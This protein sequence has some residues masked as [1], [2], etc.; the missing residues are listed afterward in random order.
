MRVLFIFGLVAVLT[1]LAG[2]AE[3]KKIDVSTIV[4]KADAEKILGEPVND[5]RIR[6]MDGQDGY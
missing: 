2:A 4:V 1:N 3:D 5:A 6:N